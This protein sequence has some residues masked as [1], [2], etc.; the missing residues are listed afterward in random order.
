MASQRNMSS[1]GVW[2]RG[3]KANILGFLGYYFK[4]AKHHY[5]RIQKRSIKIPAM[6]KFDP[7]FHLYYYTS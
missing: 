1:L 6:R 4:I 7:Y 2:G 5:P 3:S